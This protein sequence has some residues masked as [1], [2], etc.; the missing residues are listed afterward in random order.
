MKEN[1]LTQPYKNY[2]KKK[3]VKSLVTGIGSGLFRFL[4][5]PFAAVLRF[6]FIINFI[7]YFFN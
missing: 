1:I 2:Q 4:I 6:N 7:Y 5:S 3:S